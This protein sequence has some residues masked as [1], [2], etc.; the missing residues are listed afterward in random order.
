VKTSET[1]CETVTSASVIE[2]G[3][4]G[5]PDEW[6]RRAWWRGTFAR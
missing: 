3:C 6:A 5:P 2:C 4:N 1:P